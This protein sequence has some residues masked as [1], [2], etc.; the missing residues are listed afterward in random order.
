MV[1]ERMK[2]YFEWQRWNL[3]LDLLK[4]SGNNVNNPETCF[5]LTRLIVIIDCLYLLD[6]F[7]QLAAFRSI[8]SFNGNDITH[9]F[10][11]VQPLDGRTVYRN[12]RE[13][14]T[15][16]TPALAKKP[17]MNP[18]APKKVNANTLDEAPVDNKKDNGHSGASMWTVS[19][20]YPFLFRVINFFNCI[21]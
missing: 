13:E 9:N 21:I 19:R 16:A 17:E 3:F 6:F 5:L 12:V 7:F 1:R 11:P 4:H 20:K 15:T 14:Q 18:P 2:N 10:R 8:Q